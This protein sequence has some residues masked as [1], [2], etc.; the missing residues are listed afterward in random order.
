MNKSSPWAAAAAELQLPGGD[1]NSKFAYET[2]Y[3]QRSQAAAA[4]AALP[5]STKVCK[6]SKRQKANRIS[7]VPQN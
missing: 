7:F 1:E 2:I 4:A 3:A 6:S 5:K